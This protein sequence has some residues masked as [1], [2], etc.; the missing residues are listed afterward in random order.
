MLAEDH[1]SYVFRYMQV[2]GKTLERAVDDLVEKIIKAM[3]RVRNILGDGR[4]REAW[5]AFALG[6][7]QFSLSCPRYRMKELVPEYFG[8]N[9]N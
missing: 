4:A 3:E 2:H 7:V 8:L 5:E 9:G 1:D 6:F